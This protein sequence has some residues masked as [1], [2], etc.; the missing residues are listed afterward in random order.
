M[1][2][3]ASLLGPTLAEPPS[4]PEPDAPVQPFAP[5]LSHLL[6]A[7][8]RAE[9][10]PVPVATP[11]VSLP[12]DA[13]GEGDG[14]VE[15]ALETDA[16]SAGEGTP[17]RATPP[18]GPPDLHDL[19]DS[20]PSL[21]GPRPGVGARGAEPSEAG[22]PASRRRPLGVEPVMTESAELVDDPGR[23]T[24]T[25]VAIASTLASGRFAR[26]G[27][28]P[29]E[30]SEPSGLA[31]EGAGRGGRIE[32]A[33][34]VWVRPEAAT[35][36]ISMAELATM[37]QERLRKEPPTAP[38]TDAVSMRLPEDQ[39]RVLEAEITSRPAKDPAQ[40]S[41]DT[42]ASALSAVRGALARPAA[43]RAPECA[44]EPASPAD[45]EGDGTAA[46]FP[47]DLSPAGERSGTGASRHAPAVDAASPTELV[48]EAAAKAPSR[49]DRVTVE[50]V[51]DR[52]E[53]GRLRV[54]V[55]GEQ[56]QATIMPSDA[57]MAEQLSSRVSELHRTLAR[58]GFVDA[59][60]TVREP[61]VS[62]SGTGERPADRDG[63]N[64]AERWTQERARR[65]DHS[66]R[67]PRRRDQRGQNR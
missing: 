48:E 11:A 64:S 15:D 49:G 21:Q 57:R 39:G 28:A 58:H 14:S 62:R 29:N 45:L 63:E 3:I 1:N 9:Q 6:A 65:D 66:G 19:H 13:N 53:T 31:G 12:A 47:V 5:L 30:K 44:D 26:A 34:Q 61:A 32:L 41:A 18:N 38:D 24:A 51:D 36:L 8:F 27:E 33:S 23:T 16:P 2:P 60:V 40:R 37:L 59:Q 20:V 10:G 17:G 22:E 7:L 42:L 46:M 43:G 67:H 35:H 56:L 25:D 4:A 50:F 52:G 55:R 54:S